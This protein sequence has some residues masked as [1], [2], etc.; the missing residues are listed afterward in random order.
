MDETT[1]VM[2]PLM[3]HTGHY[4]YLNNKVNLSPENESSL[5]QSVLFPFT[6]WKSENDLE[7]EQGKEGRGLNLFKC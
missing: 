4:H 7:Y 2:T 5:K 6:D 1:T 3:T